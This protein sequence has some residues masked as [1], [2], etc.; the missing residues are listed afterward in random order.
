[1]SGK[2]LISGNVSYD[3]GRLTFA[4]MDVGK[5]ADEY[6]TP[7]YLYDENRIVDNCRMY[8]RAMK[9][10][11]GEGSLTAYAGKAAAFGYIYKIMSRE[12]MAADLVSIGELY[13]ASAAGFDMKNAYFHGNAKTDEEISEALR[14]GVGCF[15]VDNP[16][17]LS[18][19]DDMARKRGI[20]QK[21]LLRI[22]PGIDPHTYEAVSTGK[23][24][25]KFGVPIATGQAAEFVK[26]ALAAPNLTLIGYHCHV[27]SL[28]FD[29]E[30]SVYTD[31][32]RV[33]LDFSRDMRELV[34]YVPEYISLGG[35][36]GVRYVNSDPQVD[37][38]KNIE[39]LAEFMKC[40]SAEIGLP[41]PKVITEPGR[42]I[43]ADAGMT[44]YT[45]GSVK[46][47]KGYKTYVAVDGGMTDNPRYALYRSSY[48]VVPAIESDEKM[49][50]DVVGK[51][52]ESGD[53]IQP[54]VSLPASTRRGDRIAVLTTGAYN[55]SM[56]SNYNR[57]PRPPVVMIKD[58]E[59]TLAVRRETPA[60]VAALDLMI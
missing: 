46:N 27:G 51:C 22:T 15:V 48:T 39:R 37:I 31:A 43:V 7:A 38:P 16:D 30:S 28:V 18:V 5:I 4:G 57:I 13:T 52:C 40:H 53:I 45:V 17:E 3:G 55:Y 44:V 2:D 14:L 35:G 24:D 8:K 32:A 33:M 9:E 21:I 49:I 58:G 19:L 6:G 23:V 56:A 25:S 47:V 59:T 50:C 36:Y 20:N 26:S 12:G 41:M 11:F 34:G 29:T 42:S 54:G 10:S 60:D 1:M